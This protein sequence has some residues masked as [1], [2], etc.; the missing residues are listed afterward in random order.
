MT[1][2]IFIAV[3][4]PKEIK[5]TVRAIRTRFPK[6][7]SKLRFTKGD[8][9]HVTLAFMGQTI[10]EEVAKVAAIVDQI[11]RQF[12]PLTITIN[13][14]IGFPSLRVARALAL[15][16]QS[17]SLQRFAD[18]LRKAL[19]SRG[20]SVDLKPYVAHLTIARVKGS[21]PLDLSALSKLTVDLPQTTIGAIN[22]VQS[23]PTDHGFVHHTL[24]QVTL[25][26]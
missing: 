17:Q 25:Q 1:K 7:T 11:A 18:T 10:L 21:Q 4:A 15:R 9:Y 16:I 5:R 26:P 22:I 6:L 3:D 13:D 12:Q 23:T 24:K 14:W 2:R 8:S 20:F 19:G